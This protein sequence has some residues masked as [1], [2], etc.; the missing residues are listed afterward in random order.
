MTMDIQDRL[1]SWVGATLRESMFVAAAGEQ[2]AT[3]VSTP[4]LFSTRD[5]DGVS[6]VLRVP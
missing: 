3:R 1:G 2:P 5:R 6:H 4:N